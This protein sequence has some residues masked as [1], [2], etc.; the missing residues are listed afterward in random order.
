MAIRHQEKCGSTRA[1]GTRRHSLKPLVMGAGTLFAV[2]VGAFLAAMPASASAEELTSSSTLSATNSFSVEVT[3]TAATSDT[4]TT[5]IFELLDS[6]T[7]SVVAVTEANAVT[8]SAEPTWTAVFDS[9][10]VTTA[11]EFTYTVR[12]QLSEEVRDDGGI[13]PDGIT[14]DTTAFTVTVTAELATAVTTELAT[15]LPANL[16]P[17][18][19]PVVVTQIVTADATGNPAP[20]HFADTDT[21][22]DTEPTTPSTTAG[23]PATSPQTSSQPETQRRVEAFE[24]A[25]G[26]ILPDASV[27]APS[28]T[29]T[30]TVSTA[31]SAPTEAGNAGTATVV[32]VA[33]FDEV[34]DV[35]H[36]IGESLADRDFEIIVSSD[37]EATPASALQPSD[38][39]EATGNEAVIVDFEMPLRVTPDVVLATVF[40]AIL[41]GAGFVGVI[42]KRRGDLALEQR[43]C[44]KLADLTY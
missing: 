32:E 19:S 11:G 12:E 35:V 4:T 15:E 16:P 39:P 42:R 13:S 37:I 33:N 44:D 38:L 40:A 6:E 23:T 29:Q 24:E 2:A 1:R 18:L 34:E 5:H 17:E 22:A 43:T 28:Q 14:Y 26:V 31:E 27:T 9:I 3:K 7:N 25:E 21:D 30:I 20:V 36:G 10:P 41:L 8:E